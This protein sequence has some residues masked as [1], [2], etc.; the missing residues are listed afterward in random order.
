MW[1]ARLAV[2]AV[3]LVV[4]AVAFVWWQSSDDGTAD[5]TAVVADVEAARA[6]FTGMT[7]GTITVGGEQLRVVVADDEGERVQ[8]LRQKSDASPYDGM[9]FV[10]PSDGLVSFTMATVTDALEIVFFD[11]KGRVVDRLHMTP[12]AGTDASCPVYTPAGVFRYAL[13]TGDG[14]VYEGPLAVPR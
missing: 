5:A 12:C 2:G 4:L 6:P 7:A 1:A 11:A 8:G 13:E 9:L 3:V 10:F 14:L